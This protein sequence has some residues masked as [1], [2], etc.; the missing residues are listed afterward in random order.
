VDECLLV[1]AQAVQEDLPIHKAQLLSDMKRLSVLLGLVI[2]FH[3]IR[4]ADG[5]ARLILPG[6][7]R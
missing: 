3:E 1:E 5:V 4:L 7:N 2:N 6:A